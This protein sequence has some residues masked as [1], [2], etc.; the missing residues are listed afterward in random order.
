MAGVFISMFLSVLILF[1]LTRIIWINIVKDDGFRMELHLPII[2]IHFSKS[3][4]KGANIKKLRKKLTTLQYRKIAEKLSSLVEKSEI[5]IKRIE[6]PEKTGE[7]TNA[8]F[9]RPYRYQG[10]F[11]ALYA[12]LK[13]K[14]E[15]ITLCNNA[16]ALSSDGS[17]IR[18]NFTVKLRLYQ[19]IFTALSVLFGE[20]KEKLKK[21]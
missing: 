9:V 21:D 10:V 2:A 8:T 7:I 12:Y 3:K 15:K 16:I 14:A 1:I 4:S 13:T 6:F 5:I 17:A 19:L 20:M 18:Y 11:F